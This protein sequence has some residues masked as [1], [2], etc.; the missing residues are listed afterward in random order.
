M[1]KVRVGNRDQGF[2]S[3]PDRFATQTGNANLGDDKINVIF[4]DTDV[5]AR[6]EH[7]DNPRHA[8]VTRGRRQYQNVLTTPRTV[9]S[10]G[11]IKLPTR[12][13]VR[14]SAVTLRAALADQINLH[15]AVDG[16]QLIV[17]AGNT[18]II[19]EINGV[20]FK[21]RISIKIAIQSL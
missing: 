4:A 9:G 19:G 20:H 11:K 14:C 18:R 6:R 1:A 17:L 2:G 12:A 21:N 16:N 13:G 10:A 15:A 5:S 7:S 8:T 3:L